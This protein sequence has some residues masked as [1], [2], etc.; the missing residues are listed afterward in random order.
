MLSLVLHTL[1]KIFDSGHVQ[2]FHRIQDLTF[3]SRYSSRKMAK[4]FGNSGDLDQRQILRC[5]ALFAKYAFR[6][7]Q[8][9][10]G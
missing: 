8:T 3:F 9:K 1:G 5:F 6:G 7:L 10:M 4:L 2:I